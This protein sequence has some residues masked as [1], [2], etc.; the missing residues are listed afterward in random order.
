MVFLSVVNH[1]MILLRNITV[2]VILFLPRLLPRLLALLL[3][4]RGAFF[5]QEE[6]QQLVALQLPMTMTLSSSRHRYV[7][8]ILYWQA[9]CKK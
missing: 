4:F 8:V 3:L 2:P 1:P 5:G 6:V 9:V 7:I